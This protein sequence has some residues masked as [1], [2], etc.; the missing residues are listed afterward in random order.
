MCGRSD[1]ASEIDGA[2]QITGC[3]WRRAIASTVATI[4]ATRSATPGCG[5]ICRF[6]S[7]TTSK[8]VIR[9]A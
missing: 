1:S 2:R 3:S 9:H 5:Q 8:Q 7:L 6:G 4:S